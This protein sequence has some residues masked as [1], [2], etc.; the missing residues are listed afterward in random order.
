MSRKRQLA[1]LV[2]G[3]NTIVWGLAAPIVKPALSITTPERFL[4]YRFL[5]ASII[6]LPLL[7]V[8]L[9]RFK[10]TLGLVM[11][12][13]CLEL[14]GTSLLLWLVYTALNLTSALESS[15]IYSTSPIFVTLAGVFLLRERE[16]KQEWRGLAIALAGTLIISVS[17][18]LIS[19]FKVSGSIVGNGLMLLQNVLWAIYLVAAKRVYRHVPKLA[20]TSISFFVGA[21]SF[22]LLSQSSSNPLLLAPLELN[23]PSV[24]LAVV[25]MAIFGS[26][27]GATTYLI[28]QN[29]IEVSEAT[30]FTY[31]EA[32]V[33]L[34]AAMFFLG[35]QPTPA[36]IVGAAV[37]AIGV[38]IAEYKSHRRR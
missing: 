16:T 5:L 34:P 4:F 3:I 25:Y 30:L 6:T 26:I 27:I 14:L 17:P 13:I 36:I 23:N 31:L 2:L 9:K 18:L 35:E 32:L 21:V 33:A 12:I 7:P 11:K 22:F 8:I 37:V 15:F 28:G 20:V 19:G 10:L 29:M 24:L 1:Y 38:Y